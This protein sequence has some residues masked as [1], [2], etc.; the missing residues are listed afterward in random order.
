MEPQLSPSSFMAAVNSAYRK[1]AVAYADTWREPH[2]WMD[3]ERQVAAQW[4]KSGMSL[5]DI[6]CGPGRDAKFWSDRGAHVTGV[7]ICP[8][9][10]ARAKLDYPD[11]QFQLGDILTLE[12]TDVG[13]AQFD[14]GWIAYVLLHLPPDL[15]RQALINIRRLIKP[16]G[17]VFIATTISSV[18]RDRL[19]P[20][21]G[22]KDSKGGD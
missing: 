11:L 16:H 17:I 13:G 14:C 9:M 4:I 21:A 10:I 1:G 2:P 15:C 20:I 6:G 3:V 19:G 12:I 18:S 8:E 22:L 7:D 5:I